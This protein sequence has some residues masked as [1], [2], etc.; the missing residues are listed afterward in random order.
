MFTN[1]TKVLI[2]QLFIMY[3]AYLI[4]YIQ[5]IKDRVGWLCTHV[6]LYVCNINSSI[7]L[8]VLH[9]YFFLKCGASLSYV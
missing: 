4:V 6:Y 5:Y 8:F 2:Y 1:A 9:F 3:T 7:F